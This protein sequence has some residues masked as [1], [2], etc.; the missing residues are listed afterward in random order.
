[1]KETSKWAEIRADYYD[2][3]EEKQYIDAWETDDDDEEGSVI[4]KIDLASGEVEYLDDDAKSD[5]YAQ[6]VIKEMIE[7]GY[8]LTE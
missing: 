4:A 8:V 3:E 7:E 2:D 1:M 5:P 6:E